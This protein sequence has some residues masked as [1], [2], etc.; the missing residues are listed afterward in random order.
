MNSSSIDLETASVLLAAQARPLM[1]LPAMQQQQQ[2]RDAKG[3]SSF[4]LSLA[5]H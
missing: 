4:S 5:H 3:Q 1:A 2:A